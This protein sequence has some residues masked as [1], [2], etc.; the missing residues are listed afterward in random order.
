MSTAND[1]LISTD[2]LAAHLDDAKL[3]VI[4]ASY[5]MPALRPPSAYEEFTARHLPGAVFFD[6]DAIADRTNSLPHM[7][8]SPQQFVQQVEALG[9]GPH[10]KIAIYDSGNWMGGPRAWWMFQLYGIPGAKL[11]DGGLKKWVAEGR[12]VHSGEATPRGRPEAL[13]PEFDG[14]W[15]RRRAELLDNLQSG[16]EQVVDARA[17][18]RYE[19]SVAEPWPGRRSGR[20][21]GSFNVPFT[22]LISPDGSMKSHEQLRDIFTAAKVDLNRPI[23]TSC[24]SGVTAATLTVALTRLGVDRTAL[25]DGSWAE[26]GLP[27]GPPIATGPA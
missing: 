5:R 26:W 2:W 24:G 11:L 18:E 15:L 3:V 1:P 8:P 14:S 13:I 6:I 23:V 9:V 16:A 7:A 25:Y 22:D 21:P 20:I 27:D 10:S 12:P 4:D 19:G 17:R